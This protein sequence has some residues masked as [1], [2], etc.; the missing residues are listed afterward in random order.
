MKS[1]IRAL[2]YITNLVSIELGYQVY[3]DFG[4]YKELQKNLIDKG[5]EHRQ[6]YPLVFL[7]LDITEGIEQQAK[8]VTETAQTII[9]LNETDRAWDSRE[10]FVRQYEAVLHPIYSSFISNIKQSIY[11]IDSL[12][13]Y[14]N[15]PHNKTDKYFFSSTEAKAQNV[16]AAYLDALEITG[17]TLLLNQEPCLGPIPGAFRLI[18]ES[19]EAI[20]TEDFKYL[21]TN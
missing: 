8:K 21:T 16:L 18:T 4:S 11:F 3:F 15:L 19:G 2:E 7:Q 13:E 9:I 14:G 5:K 12:N 6:K 17:L 20:L 1:I 10:R